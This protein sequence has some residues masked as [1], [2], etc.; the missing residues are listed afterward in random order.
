MKKA[1]LMPTAEELHAITEALCAIV[2]TTRN[3]EA[4][5]EYCWRHSLEENRKE[6]VTNLMKGKSYKD[7][8]LLN[9]GVSRCVFHS[10]SYPDIVFKVIYRNGG[11]TQNKAEYSAYYKASAKQR[12][13][14]AQVYNLTWCEHVI[15]MEYIKGTTWHDA[16][17]QKRS[18]NRQKYRKIMSILLNDDCDRKSLYMDDL[19]DN[20]IMITPRNRIVAV[21]YGYC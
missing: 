16:G 10:P 1:P 11:T 14:M 8:V 20:N 2:P 9:A 18:D 7:F 17:V 4:R 19:H 15:V 12:R 13:F 5:R 3:F 6:T 21:D